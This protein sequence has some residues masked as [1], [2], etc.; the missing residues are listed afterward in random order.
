MTMYGQRNN[1]EACEGCIPEVFEELNRKA[2]P[3]IKMEEIEDE[4]QSE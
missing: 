4:A 1:H 3:Y 2:V